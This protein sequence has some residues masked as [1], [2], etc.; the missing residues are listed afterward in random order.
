MAIGPAQVDIEY[1]NT[2]SR[3]KSF[4]IRDQ[5]N[6]A[7]DLSSKTLILTIKVDPS[8]AVVATLSTTASTITVSGASDNVVNLIFNLDISRGNYV[9]DL[10]NE[11]DD[12][13]IMYGKLSVTGEVYE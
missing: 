1:Y 4:T 8:S 11:T 5:D 12:T 7:V 3:T 2:E 13:F 9:Y 10:Y 6:A